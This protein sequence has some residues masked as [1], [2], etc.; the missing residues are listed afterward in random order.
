MN[1]IPASFA[2]AGKCK[3]AFVDPPDAATTTAAFSNY[4]L[5]TISLGL[6]FFAN[7][8]IT[9]LPLETANLSRFS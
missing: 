5:V 2:I 6:I 4:F 9:A 3:A 1:L 7:K 8:F